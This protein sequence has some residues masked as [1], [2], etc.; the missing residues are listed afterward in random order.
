MPGKRYSTEPVVA[1]LR[2]AEKLQGQGQTIPQV[3]KKLGLDEA[4]RLRALTKWTN[5]RHIVMDQPISIR[6]VRFFSS[7]RPNDRSTASYLAMTGRLIGDK[8]GM[9]T[10]VRRGGASMEPT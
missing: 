9:G 4:H 5:S 3:C 8:S 6:G 7:I 2:E 1:K 10:G